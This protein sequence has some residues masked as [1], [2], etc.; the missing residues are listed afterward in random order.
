MIYYKFFFVL[1]YVFLLVNMS[2]FFESLVIL[3]KDLNYYFFLG[4]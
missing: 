1:F 2:F 3:V 4:I